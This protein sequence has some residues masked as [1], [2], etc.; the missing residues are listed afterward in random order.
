MIFDA[1]QGFSNALVQYQLSESASG[2]EFGGLDN[3]SYM[4]VAVAAGNEIMVVHG[5]GRKEAVALSGREERFNVGAGV[6][7]LALGEFSWDRDGRTE[8]ATLMSDGLV[9]IVQNLKRDTRPFSSEEA[10]ERTR[11]P[12]GLDRR[13][14][15]HDG[16]HAGVGLARIDPGGGVGVSHPE[17]DSRRTASASP[18]R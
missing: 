2:I 5:W 1:A 10:A 9:Q 15:A 18:A 4:D 3:D 13:Q 14:R 17:R 8:I 6:R 7:G 12:A 16:A 11:G